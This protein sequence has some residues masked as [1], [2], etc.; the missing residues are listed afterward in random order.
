MTTLHEVA[1]EYAK[2]EWSGHVDE[3][4]DGCYSTIGELSVNAFKAGI[5]SDYNKSLQIESQIK[6]LEQVRTILFDKGT[7]SSEWDYIITDLQEQLKQLQ[8]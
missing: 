4:I 5:E 1:K 7:S 6:V 3:T 8:P 2:R